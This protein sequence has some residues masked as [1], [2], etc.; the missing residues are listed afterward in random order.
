MRHYIVPSWV[1]ACE[2]HSEWQDKLWSGESPDYRKGKSKNVMDYY[3]PSETEQKE[4][5]K[6]KPKVDMSIP[7]EI[8]QLDK[9]DFDI[10]TNEKLYRSGERSEEMYRGIKKILDSKHEKLVKKLDRMGFFNDNET[11]EG[12][13]SWQWMEKPSLPYVFDSKINEKMFRVYVY[14]LKQTFKI[15]RNLLRKY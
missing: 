5:K 1:G 4:S 9:L 8:R 14:T 15:I 11:Q 12:D 2:D 3:T 6:T 10:L 7:L 13:S